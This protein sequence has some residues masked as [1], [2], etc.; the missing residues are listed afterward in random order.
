MKRISLFIITS[1]FSILVMAQTAPSATKPAPIDP[2][3]QPA[4]QAT[5]VKTAKDNKNSAAAPKKSLRKTI[6]KKK[7]IQHVTPVK[8]NTAPSQTGKAKDDSKK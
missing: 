7:G 6:P 1:L 5:S 2:K 8:K 4:K 3:V